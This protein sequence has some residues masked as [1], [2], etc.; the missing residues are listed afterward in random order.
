MRKIKRRL[1]SQNIFLLQ[2]VLFFLFYI[3][4]IEPTILNAQVKPQPK[5]PEGPVNPGGEPG[6]SEPGGSEPG[7]SEPGGS[8]PG[9]SEPGGSEPGGSEPGGSEPGGSEPGGSEPGGSEPGGSEPGGSEPG[10][11][12]PGGGTPSTGGA[13][14]VEQCSGA[15]NMAIG[16]VCNESSWSHL[17]KAALSFSSK[18]NSGDIKGACESAK[19]LN[20]LGKGIN[21]HFM[22]SCGGA[23]SACISACGTAK[24][25]ATPPTSP[26]HAQLPTIEAH[27]SACK[28]KKTSNRVGGLAQ[29]AQNAI[30]FTSSGKCSEQV[31]DDGPSLVST[32]CQSFPPSL[33]ALCHQ[34]GPQSLCQQY[35]SLPICRELGGAGNNN[36][37]PNPAAEPGRERFTLETCLTNPSAPG[38]KGSICGSLSSA[39]L[40]DVCNTDGV[41]S[42]CNNIPSLPQCRGLTAQR[43]GNVNCGALPS[44]NLAEE[45]RTSGSED[46]CQK[47]SQLTICKNQGKSN[48]VAEL[49][50]NGGSGGGLG[51]GSGPF[52]SSPG[53]GG[54]AF[55]SS[56]DDFKKSGRTRGSEGTTAQAFDRIRVG[57]GGGGASGGGSGSRR[58][59]YNFS[60]GKFRPPSFKSLFGKK[61]KEQERTISSINSNNNVSSANGLTNFQKISRSYKA[62]YPVFFGTQVR[63][64]QVNRNF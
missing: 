25:I 45:C 57:G 55:P 36:L 16:Q 31:S 20:F 54:K 58:R 32:T 41:E 23:L 12:E 47:H 9:G 46:F 8:E 53:G 37:A 3:S 29:I 56:S 7:G 1:F 43:G 22:L 51:G 15:Y 13:A 24:G 42:L 64:A 40:R 52:S 17:T 11:S 62:R 14:S 39:P 4:F 26:T 49:E 38:C 60:P 21:T 35:P 5:V 59:G 27:L 28:S 61:K 30:A 44:Q 6:G 18:L 2:S 63:Q 50:K 33:Q 48:Q 34:R 19:T 10:G